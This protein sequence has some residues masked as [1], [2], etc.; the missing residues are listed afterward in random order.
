MKY[1]S[2]GKRNI[3]MKKGNKAKVVASDSS[4]RCRAAV[5]QELTFTFNFT[6]FKSVQMGEE[7]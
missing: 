4:K 1:F 7:E 3:F 6:F 2:A 5:A